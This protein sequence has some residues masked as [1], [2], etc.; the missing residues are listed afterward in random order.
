MKKVP[1][2]AMMAAA[3]SILFTVE[4][5]IPNPFPWM[6]LGIANMVSLLTLKWWGVRE[7]IA[8]FFV[9]LMIGGL[10]TGSLFQP[11]FVLSCLGGIA[12][13]FIMA[14][15]MPF[16]GR[17]FSL[18]GISILGALFH[19]GMQLVVAYGLYVRHFF[20]LSMIPLFLA[21]ALVSGTIVGTISL[22]IHHRLSGQFSH[23]IM[24]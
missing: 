20:L 14:M 3:A 17:L 8:V 11:S 5:L 18:I 19:N 1:F 2:L 21:N 9:R 6:R 13:L 10:L 15:V 24:A 4:S 7:T 12:A 22:L 23:K 16:E